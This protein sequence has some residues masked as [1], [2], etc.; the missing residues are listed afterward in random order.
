MGFF[1][2]GRLACIAG[3]SLHFSGEREDEREDERGAQ[4]MLRRE[5]REKNIRALFVARDS[6]SPEKSC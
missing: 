1:C 4:V 2:I 6:R 3:L 5:G